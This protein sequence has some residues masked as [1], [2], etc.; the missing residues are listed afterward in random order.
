MALGF[1]PLP[2]V[3]NAY[4]QLLAAADQRLMPLFNYFSCEWLVNIPPAMWNVHQSDMRT[5]NHLEGWHNRFNNLVSQHHVNIWKFVQCLR[6]EQCSTEVA[7]QQI[8]SG[9]TV[10][11]GNGRYKRINRRIHKLE[12]RFNRGRLNILQLIDG[13]SYNLAD[14]RR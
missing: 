8:A 6:E 5:N 10:H 7:V 13:I 3:R 2:F 12:R 14:Y 4:Q 9:R 1:V 11:R